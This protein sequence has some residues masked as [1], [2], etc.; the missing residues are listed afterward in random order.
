M[1]EELETVQLD[2]HAEEVAYQNC[3]VMIYT[4]VYIGHQPG[5]VANPAFGYLNRRKLISGTS[6]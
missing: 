6:Q 2:Y 4:V 3:V 1:S 5:I